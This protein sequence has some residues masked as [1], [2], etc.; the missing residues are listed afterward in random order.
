[1]YH[2]HFMDVQCC[3]QPV[4]LLRRTREQMFVRSLRTTSGDYRIMGYNAYLSVEIIK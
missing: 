1:M 4:A 3:T 2:Y